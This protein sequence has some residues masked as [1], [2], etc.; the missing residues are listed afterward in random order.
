MPSERDSAVVHGGQKQ[1]A[2][3]VTSRCPSIDAAPTRA[4]CKSPAALRVS[5]IPRE[6]R[7]P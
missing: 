2:T 5:Y 1:E 7:R 3:S 6:D 4:A